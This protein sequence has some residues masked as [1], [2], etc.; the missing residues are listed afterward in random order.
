M[1]NKLVHSFQDPLIEDINNLLEDKDFK[2]KVIQAYNY[3]LNDKERG[4]PEVM[5]GLLKHYLLDISNFT[6][7]LM[8]IYI[9]KEVKQI[10]SLY[11]NNKVDASL[12][13][14]L[15]LKKL[16]EQTL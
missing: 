15:L 8:M 14:I 16:N 12:D 1:S 13:I 4:N 5:Y 7:S 2:R 3:T 6:R 10:E 9:N 11:Q